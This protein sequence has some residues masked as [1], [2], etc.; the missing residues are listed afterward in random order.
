MSVQRPIR[1]A[2]ELAAARLVDLDDVGGLD[3]VAARYAI[4]I[5]PELV[6]LID[7]VAG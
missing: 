6:E 7:P 4:A 3:V 2:R 1:T 5:T